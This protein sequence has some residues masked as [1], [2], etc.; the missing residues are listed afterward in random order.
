MSTT[1]NNQTNNKQTVRFYSKEE[2]KKLKEIAKGK[3][4]INRDLLKEFCKKYDR[5]FASATIKVY[6]LRKKS[7]FSISTKKYVK[8]STPKVNLVKQDKTIMNLSKGQ[9]RIPINT[10]NIS[11]ENGKFYFVAK[12]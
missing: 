7:S 2:I 8:K 10:W 9:F 11:N 6:D 12:F 5:S 4:P 1:D 3:Q